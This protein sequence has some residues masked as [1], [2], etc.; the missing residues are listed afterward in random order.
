M[1]DCAVVILSIMEIV[2]EQFVGAGASSGLTALRSLRLLRVFRL[3]KSWKDFQVGR[4]DRPC[5]VCRAAA[6]FLLT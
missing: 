4:R 5:K 2:V 1:F 6:V 3:A